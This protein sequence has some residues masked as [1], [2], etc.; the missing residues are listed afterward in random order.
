MGAYDKHEIMGLIDTIIEE[1]RVAVLAVDTGGAPHL[2]WMTPGC[3]H[4]R[5]GTIFMVSSSRFSKVEQIQNNPNAELMV[6]S[7]ALD[8]IINIRGKINLLN[9]PSI[10][11]ETLECIGRHLHTFWN[12]N[13]PENE[14][15]VLE[16]V[17]EQAVVYLPQKGSRISVDFSGED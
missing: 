2:R 15:V 16:L 9:N 8:K 12:L 10:R 5:P 1:N 11:S 17:I 3:I 13:Q 4:E 6:Q 14:L 7:R